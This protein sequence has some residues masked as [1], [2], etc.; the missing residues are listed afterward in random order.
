MAREVWQRNYLSGRYN[1]WP[2]DAVVSL[3]LRHY[4]DAPRRD[5]VR[6]L[7]LGCGG[8]NN[9]LF[10]AQSGFDFRAV[11]AA[12]EAVRLTK[13]RLRLDPDD[14]RVVAG[15]FVDLP[16]ADAEFDAV[17]DRASLCCNLMPDLNRAIGEIGRVLE[18]GGR[19]IGVDLYGEATSDLTLGR[20]L[21]DG[22]YV[23]FTLGLFAHSEEVHAFTPAQIHE[24]FAG[25]EIELLE[26]VI[27]E[28]CLGRS[29]PARREHFNLVA[30]LRDGVGGR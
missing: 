12:P 29:G 25:F 11:D 21:D 24:L 16:F 30:R 23:G 7:D 27:V 19:F 26:R 10:L 17:V 15:D 22:D 9:T 28:D 18:P 8:G 4:G 6:I 5:R 3:V 2:Y 1:R 20:A 13:E 14:D